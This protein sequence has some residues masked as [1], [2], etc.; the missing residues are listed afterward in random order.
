MPKTKLVFLHDKDVSIFKLQHVCENLSRGGVYVWT[1]SLCRNLVNN[2]SIRLSVLGGESL[3][4]LTP[5]SRSLDRVLSVTCRQ[6]RICSI[7]N[8]FPYSTRNLKII[9]KVV[10]YWWKNFNKFDTFFL[11]K[12]AAQCIAFILISLKLKMNC[13]NFKARQ[14]QYT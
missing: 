2:L 4:I 13:S 7:F 1:F 9:K 10:K 3:S 14:V 8:D 12:L 6:S 5:R 11:Q